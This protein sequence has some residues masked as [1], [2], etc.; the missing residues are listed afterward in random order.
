MAPRM[1]Q[2]RVQVVK[3]VSITSTMRRRTA[4]AIDVDNPARFPLDPDGDL[5]RF[6]ASRH[7]VDGPGQHQRPANGPPKR[8]HDL[9]DQHPRQMTS[10]GGRHAIHSVNEHQRFAANAA[11]ASLPSAA[12]LLT[13]RRLPPAS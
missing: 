9:A 11:A 13:L 3:K 10:S 6:A 2:M 4:G 12:A 7:Q 8:R 5:R 1:G